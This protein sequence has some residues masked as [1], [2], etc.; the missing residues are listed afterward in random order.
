MTAGTSPKVELGKKLCSQVADI[1]VKSII[2]LLH[3]A[4]PLRLTIQQVR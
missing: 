2:N 4:T 1:V 3:P